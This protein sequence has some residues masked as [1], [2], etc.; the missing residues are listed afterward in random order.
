M[1]EEIVKN[2]LNGTIR[3][4]NETYT[5]EGVQYTGAKFIIKIAID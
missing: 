2:H 3:V 5:F 4:E 1:S